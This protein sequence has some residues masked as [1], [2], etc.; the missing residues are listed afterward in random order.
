MK[1]IQD[2]LGI[3]NMCDLLKKEMCGIFNIKDVTKKQKRKYVRSKYQITK[4]PE[5]DN[6]YKYVKNDVAEKIIKNCRGV[7]KC[8][9]GVNRSDKENQSLDKF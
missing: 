6:R 9:D 2:G 5:D 1:D 7:K 4:S 8:N 3:K